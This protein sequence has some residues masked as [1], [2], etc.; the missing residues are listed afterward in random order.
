MVKEKKILPRLLYKARLKMTKMKLCVINN[1]PMVVWNTLKSVPNGELLDSC[2]WVQPFVV[3]MYI[4]IILR[5]Q[6]IFLS[7][8]TFP[9]FPQIVIHIST[10]V[11]HMCNICTEPKIKAFL[12]LHILLVL[13]SIFTFHV[14]FTGTRLATSRSARGVSNELTSSGI[15]SRNF[16]S[17]R[18]LDC[19]ARRTR[20]PGLQP[21]E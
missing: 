11:L 10:T 2:P 14:W 3:Y 21:E 6:T 1:M 19:L 4:V 15:P 12:N 16:Q 5:V 17:R 18:N 9:N 7:A 20:Q 8:G 13:P